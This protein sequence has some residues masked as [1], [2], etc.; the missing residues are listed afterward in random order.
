[1]NSRVIILSIGRDIVSNAEAQF[2]VKADVILKRGECKPEDYDVL[3]RE[4]YQYLKKYQSEPINLI[5]SGPV[6]FAFTLGQIVGLNHF[7]LQVFHFDS[8]RRSYLK[9]PIP[10]RDDIL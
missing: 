3:R 8:S 10:T 1:M 5:L 2:G 9:V 7:D 6:A 4:T